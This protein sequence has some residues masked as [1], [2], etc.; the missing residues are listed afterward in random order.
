MDKK[1][2]S[3]LSLLF[4]PL[5]DVGGRMFIG[6]DLTFASES[7]VR[8]LSFCVLSGT[9]LTDDPRTHVLDLASFLSSG[10]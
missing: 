8:G 6:E 4:V 1:E 10:R 2:S 9:S 7:I 3:S 5:V